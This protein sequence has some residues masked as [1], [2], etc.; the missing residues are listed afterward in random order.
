MDKFLS[1]LMLTKT[2][3]S[4]PIHGPKIIK[5]TP[6]TQPINHDPIPS[7]FNINTNHCMDFHANSND[8]NEVDLYQLAKNA[9][10]WLN[11]YILTSLHKT[12]NIL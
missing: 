3:L 8:N 4:F 6:P 1:F 11:L 5:T 7:S 2:I 10:S 12:Y 9:L